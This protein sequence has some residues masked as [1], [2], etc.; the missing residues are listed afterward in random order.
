M[1]LVDLGRDLNQATAITE[2]KDP[3]C[4]PFDEFI[5]NVADDGQVVVHVLGFEQRLLHFGTNL[6]PGLATADQQAG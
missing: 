3:K 5:R 2:S 1:E 6:P 4:S